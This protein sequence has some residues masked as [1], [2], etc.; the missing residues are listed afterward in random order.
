MLIY[1]ECPIFNSKRVEM[2]NKLAD[3]GFQ[4]AI[5]KLF[6]GQW[7]Q[8]GIDALTFLKCLLL[9]GSTC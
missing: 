6:H 2:M 1:I 4:P 3:L 8:V 9:V 7:E 5:R